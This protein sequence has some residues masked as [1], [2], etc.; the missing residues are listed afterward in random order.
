MNNQRKKKLINPRLQGRFLTLLLAASGASVLVHAGLSSWALASLASELPND[1]RRLHDA[2]PGT[3]VLSSVATLLAVL[4]IF[5]MLGIAGTFRVFGP[6]Y[7]FR[8]FLTAVCKGEHP[9]PCRIRKD[10]ELHDL[11]ELLNRATESVRA[12][13][14]RSTE[15]TAEDLVRKAA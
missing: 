1:A 14:V 6:L 4:P 10:D 9:E 3:V 11:C 15:Q 13:Q 8:M 7:R 2:I 12:E 5:L